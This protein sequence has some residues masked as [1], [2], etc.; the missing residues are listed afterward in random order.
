MKRIALITTLIII[1]AFVGGFWFAGQKESNLG[2][3]YKVPTF[4]S[5]TTS[6]VTANLQPATSTVVLTQKGGRAYASIC[7]GTNDV[8]YL[9]LGNTAT[10]ST[11]YGSIRIPAY[12]CYEITQDNLY[13]GE[14]RYVPVA[15]TTTLQVVEFIGY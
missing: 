8:G 10:T 5:V 6:Q 12:G 15:A 4:N 1:T 2:G 9:Q 11:A 3:V 13:T 14:I 7:N